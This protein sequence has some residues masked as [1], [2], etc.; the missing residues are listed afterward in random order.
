MTDDER[1]QY[2]RNWYKANKEK[3]C[4]QQKEEIKK[5]WASSKAK[6]RETK[7]QEN[8][9]AFKESRTTEKEKE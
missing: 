5:S 9:E 6:L 4:E 8:P 7:R 1:R 2:H 3:M